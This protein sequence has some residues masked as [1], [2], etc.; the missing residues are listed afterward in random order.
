MAVLDERSPLD[1]GAQAARTAR[2]AWEDGIG[3]WT[4]TTL[5]RMRDEYEQR[6][7]YLGDALLD[8]DAKGA[9]SAI[10][11]HAVTRLAERLALEAQLD[12]DLLDDLEDDLHRGTIDAATAVREV[13]A[14]AGRQLDV[15][16]TEVVL[17]LRRIA[18]SALTPPRDPQ[19]LLDRIVRDL[20]TPAR[21]AQTREWAHGFVEGTNGR[22]PSLAAAVAEAGEQPIAGDPALDELWIGATRGLLLQHEAWRLDGP[23]HNDLHAVL[24]PF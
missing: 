22:F 1:L 23:H 4:R 13:A 9:R 14:G 15:P 2:E 17:A 24:G 12:I 11:T 19:R 5:A 7:A 21:R 3:E 16:S 10:A 20:A 18:G 8:V 6:A